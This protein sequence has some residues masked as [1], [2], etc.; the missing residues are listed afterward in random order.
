MGSIPDGLTQAPGQ[1]NGCSGGGDPHAEDR[2]RIP[3]DAVVVRGG[4]V[5]EDQIRNGTGVSI[6][7]HGHISGVSVNTGPTVAAATAP[8]PSTGYRASRTTRSGSR[9]PERF[10]RLV[11]GSAPLPRFGTPITPRSPACPPETW[12]A[13]SS[14]RPIPMPGRKN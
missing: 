9:R 10:A 5:T 7:A 14:S 4:I 2:K 13:S 8:N 11:E 6:D 3:D 12:Q 1:G